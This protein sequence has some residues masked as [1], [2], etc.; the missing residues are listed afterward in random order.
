MWC[1]PNFRDYSSYKRVNSSCRGIYEFV[2]PSLIRIWN[3]TA[4]SHFVKQAARANG[5]SNLMWIY[6]STLV[7]KMFMPILFA[8]TQIFSFLAQ[9]EW[10][11]IRSQWGI[12]IYIHIGKIEW[13]ANVIKWKQFPR[14]WPF[15]RG[16]HRSPVN[17]PHQ[18]QWR[19][20]LM[21]SVICALNIRLGKQSEAGDLRR[22]C[23]HY[24]VI[25][26]KFYWTLK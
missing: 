13:H 12:E 4:E 11:Y 21:F 2:W 24:D 22:H 14:Y 9:Y 15:L 7:S 10:S 25:I 20:A 1:W 19:R 16:I 8:D 3:F 18:V 5:W 17:F 26:M 6:D 23:V